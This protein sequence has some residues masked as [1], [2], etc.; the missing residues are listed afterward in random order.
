MRTGANTQSAEALRNM[1]FVEPGEQSK[2]HLLN[3]GVVDGIDERRQ[4]EMLCGERIISASIGFWKSFLLL[5]WQSCF[6]LE[7]GD[8]ELTN[9]REVPRRMKIKGT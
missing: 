4:L 1:V 3:M 6:G 5:I 9:V 7:D 8:P 2:S